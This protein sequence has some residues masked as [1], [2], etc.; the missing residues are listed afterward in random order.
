MP[1]YDDD[2]KYA[3]SIITRP[4]VMSDREQRF[5]FDTVIRNRKE[6]FGFSAKPDG[7]FVL[8]DSNNNLFVSA[9]NRFYDS[10]YHNIGVNDGKRIFTF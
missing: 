7:I 3:R 2:I 1:K 9:M 5:F 6:F 4:H 8:L 10:Q